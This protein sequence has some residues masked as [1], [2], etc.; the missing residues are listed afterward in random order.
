MLT[1]STRVPNTDD[2]GLRIREVFEFARFVY[3]LF[4]PNTLITVSCVQ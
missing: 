1:F 2:I 4:E 3:R